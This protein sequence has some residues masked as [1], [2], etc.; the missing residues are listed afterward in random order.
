[1][2]RIKKFDLHIEI[3]HEAS[4]HYAKSVFGSAVEFE[5]YHTNIDDA[6]YMLLADMHT[7]GVYSSLRKD[8]ALSKYPLPGGFNSPNQ[9]VYISQRKHMFDLHIE[10]GDITGGT[11]VYS[12]TEFVNPP[13][14]CEIPIANSDVVAISDLVMEMEAQ[15]VIMQLMNQPSM[16]IFPFGGTSSLSSSSSSSSS[17]GTGPVT[18]AKKKKD[19]PK[20]LPS[21]I[22]SDLNYPACK[23]VCTSFEHFLD[24]KCHA[25]CPWRF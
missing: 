21:D 5:Q 2:Q 17:P 9:R 11:G 6:I 24:K 15:G 8:P 1:M 7:N 19:L 16:S 12:R 13:K 22:G 3:G 25:I 10:V 14:I 18:T 20:R 4:L 23:D